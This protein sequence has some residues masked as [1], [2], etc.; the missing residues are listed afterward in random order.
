[1]RVIL[2]QP[3]GFCAGV[4][5]AIEIVERALDKYR[6]PVY[7]RHEIVHN[8]HV[9]EDL[10]AK[11]AVFVEEIDEVVLAAGPR[12]D[13]YLLPTA[14]AIA[15]L[16]DP[17]LMGAAGGLAAAL[18]SCG[19]NINH[20]NTMTRVVPSLRMRCIGGYGGYGGYLS[21]WLGL[22]ARHAMEVCG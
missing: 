7:V 18:C 8:R 22:T 12:D 4:V 9:V 17:Q 3:R 6:A 10:K 21:C 11:G 19:G 14:A 13:N 15:S 16:I 1:M 20:R 5:R 2:A